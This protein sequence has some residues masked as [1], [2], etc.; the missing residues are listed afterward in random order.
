[1]PF[2]LFPIV[3]S[4][5]LLALLVLLMA[6]YKG[7]LFLRATRNE[8][9]PHI[10]MRGSEGDRMTA[11]AQREGAIDKWGK[12]LTLLAVVYGLAIA[13]IYLYSVAMSGPVR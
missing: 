1:M 6:A 3:L 4:W 10:S 7:I 2:N 8:F 5:A 12:V 9:A 11:A 13:G